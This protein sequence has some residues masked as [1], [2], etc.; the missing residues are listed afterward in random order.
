MYIL[1]GRQKD[2]RFWTSTLRIGAPIILPTL[3][4]FPPS[5]SPGLAKATN[6]ENMKT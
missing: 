1:Q 4:V 2:I 3:Y 6:L 5:I